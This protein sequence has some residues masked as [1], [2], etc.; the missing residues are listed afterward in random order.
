MRAVVCNL[1]RGTATIETTMYPLDYAKKLL[2]EKCPGPRDAGHM[3]GEAYKNE[4]F[5]CLHD[6]LIRCRIDGKSS[7]EQKKFRQFLGE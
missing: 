7:K 3:H 5:V 1:L 4:C 2:S 6:A